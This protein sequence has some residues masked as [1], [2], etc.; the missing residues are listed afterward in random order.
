MKRKMWTVL[1]AG[2]LVLPACK[3]QQVEAPAE[4]TEKTQTTKAE[5]AAPTKDDALATARKNTE[6]F[7]PLPEAFAS[8]DNP[9]TPAKVALGRTLYYD[10]R[11]SQGDKVSCN[12]CHGLD[13]FGVD[14]KQFST[15]HDGR[16]GGRNAPTV[17]NAAGQIAQFWDG[18]AANVE[19]QAGGPMLNPVEMGMPSEDA[20][21]A[22]LTKIKGYPALFKKAFP[23]SK[24]ALTFAHVT[25]AIG[26]FERGLVTPARFDKFLAG[27]AKAL[28]AQELRGFNKFVDIGC[29][30]CHNGARVG[31]AMYQ[32]VGLVE[33]W[34]NQ[35]DKGRLG[36]TKDEADMMKF[37]VPV[38]R[39]I[40]KTGPYFHDGSVAKL[41]EAVKMMAKYQLGKELSDEDVADIVAFLKALTGEVP[42]DYVKKPALPGEKT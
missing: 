33:A 21:V 9:I 20:V 29:S 15:G 1:M 34:P 37:K 6:A 28:S 38:L 27:D 24:E 2:L 39:N 23:D 11:L 30:G 13:S 18:R 14:G 31:G 10:V 22:K 19:A 36:V 4:P 5:P 8:K 32:K 25:Q 35:S 3:K 12:S 42:A 26:A 17:Y 16:K 7:A 41:P 40:A